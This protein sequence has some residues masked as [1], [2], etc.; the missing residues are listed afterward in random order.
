MGVNILHRRN[1]GFHKTFIKVHLEFADIVYNQL[2]L[3]TILSSEQLLL[4]SFLL[5][6]CF[7]YCFF[8]SQKELG[9]T[10]SYLQFL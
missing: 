6:I 5:L 9:F 1:H 3:L 8:Y 7:Y 2:N 4:L 10:N